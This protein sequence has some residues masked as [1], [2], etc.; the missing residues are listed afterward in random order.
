MAGLPTILKLKLPEIP[1]SQLIALLRSYDL[2]PAI[3]FFP[4]RRRCDEAAAETALAAK[5]NENDSRQVARR[6]LVREFA[7]EHPEVSSHRHLQAIIKGGVASH[8]A[9]HIPAWKLLIERLMA[10]GLLDAIF[11]TSTVAAGVDFPARTVVISHADRR[12]SNG[13]RN[14]T[15]S[16]LQQMTGR[17]GRRGRDLVGFAVVAP[18]LHQDPQSIARLLTARPD[19]LESQF[20]ATYTTLLNL[21]DAYENFDQVRAIAENS[22]AF[23]E[24]ARSI[25][26]LEQERAALEAAME[27]SLREQGCAVSGRSARGFERLASARARLQEGTTLTRAEVRHSWLDKV[28]APGRVVGLGRSGK[29]YL[30]VTWRYGESVGGVRPDGHGTSTALDRIGVVFENSYQLREDSI[31]RAFDDMKEGSNPRLTEPRLRDEKLGEDEGA[32][33]IND[34]LEKFIPAGLAEP[35]RAKCETALW[36][37]MQQATEF[38]LA[39]RGIENLRNEIWEPFEHRARVLDQFGYLDLGA[40]RVTESGKWLADLRV[41][42]PLLVGEALRHGLIDQLDAARTAALMAALAADEDRDFGELELNDAVMTALTRFEEIAFAVSNEEWKQGVEPAPGM[43][44]SA[45]AAAWRWGEEI[46]WAD[47]VRETKAEEGD[48][49]RMLSRTGESLLQIA[50]LR[51]SQPTAARI[52]A[53]AAELMLR[54]PVRQ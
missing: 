23:R 44:F 43:N 38:E 8:H 12:D 5:R 17:A 14:L 54:E 34:L 40:Q 21:L 41:D 51:E 29:R 24:T 35:E 25:G 16:E 4:A 7:A 1:P 2:L 13:W 6:D 20:R 36:S 37:V 42:R 52:A 26:G 45:A 53:E 18:S 10:G 22:F 9:G 33:L 39:T 11:A 28:V 3:I 30:F 47:L 50:K 19:P 49:V 46:E 31:E 32:G 27:T 15:A 48:L